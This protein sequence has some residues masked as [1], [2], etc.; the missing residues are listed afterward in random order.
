M[1]TR[2]FNPRTELIADAAARM[3]VSDM[4]AHDALEA[5]QA[6]GCAC[7][8]GTLGHAMRQYYLNVSEHGLTRLIRATERAGR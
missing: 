2:L 8:A 5:A 6:E 4:T 1:K 3:R 7:A